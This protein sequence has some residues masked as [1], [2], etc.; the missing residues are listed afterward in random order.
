MSVLENILR[1]VDE[2]RSFGYQKTEWGAKFYGRMPHVAPEA[3][4]HRVYAGL[5]ADQLRQLERLVGGGLPD[6]L[7]ALLEE[8]N[9]LSLFDRC[10]AVDGLRTEYSRGPE[11]SSFPFAM[12]TGNNLERPRNC[13]KGYLFFGSYF[14]DAS[15]LVFDRETGHVLWLPRWQA[16]PILRRWPSIRAMLESESERLSRLF[17]STGHLLDPKNSTLPSVDAN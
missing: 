11:A 1:C 6:E 17:D 2:A 16:G 8:A 14:E 4:F 12:E 3:W 15:P 7:A 13:P 5:N 10:L 9:G